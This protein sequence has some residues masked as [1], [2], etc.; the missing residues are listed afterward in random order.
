[1]A[2]AFT[3]RKG[4]FVR[5]YTRLRFGAREFVCQHWRSYPGQMELFV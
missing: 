3:R 4:V 5:A 1:M 2:M